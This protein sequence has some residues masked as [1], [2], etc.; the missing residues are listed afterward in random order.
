MEQKNFTTPYLFRLATSKDTLALVELN[1]KWQADKISNAQKS[2]GFLSAQFNATDF[3]T[4]IKNEE[5][6]VTLHNDKVIGYYLLNNFCETKKYH[7]AKQIVISLI[8]KNKIP[9][10]CKVGIGAQAL[11]DKEH[12]GKGLSRPMLKLLC[13]QVQSKYDYLYS[14]ISKQNSKAYQVHTKEGWFVVEE[15]DNSHY[16]L[17][18]PKITL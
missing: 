9:N 5:V 10:S 18:D 11:I 1:Y 4:L 7:E 14:S 6:I 16:V 2:D 8:A 15:N 17:L 3:E 13:E 12:Q